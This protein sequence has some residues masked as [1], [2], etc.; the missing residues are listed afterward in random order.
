MW[1]K[2]PE[3]VGLAAVVPPS[4]FNKKTGPSLENPTPGI[5]AVL[6]SLGHP[7]RRPGSVRFNRGRWEN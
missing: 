3:T 1:Q 4:P 5:V 2:L 6:R 7:I